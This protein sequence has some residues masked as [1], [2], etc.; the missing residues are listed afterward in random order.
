MQALA[1]L[2]LL[3]S[4]GGALGP[5]SRPSLIVIQKFMQLVGLDTVVSAGP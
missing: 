1:V 4:V 3:L 5:L 2:L